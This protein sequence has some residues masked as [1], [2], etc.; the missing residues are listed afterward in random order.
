MLEH[1]GYCGIDCDACPA[2]L[3]T[4]ADDEEALARIA[5]EWSEMYG[6]E[7]PSESIPCAGCFAR[8]PE[9]TGCHAGECAIRSCAMEKDIPTCAE[10]PDFACEKLLDFLACVPEAEANL[11]ARRKR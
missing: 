11:E 1:G 4:R 10:C 9:P 6:A 7:I 5:A 3:A 8:E 2:F